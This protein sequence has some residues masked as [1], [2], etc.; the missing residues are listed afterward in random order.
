ME[1]QKTIKKEFTLEGVGLHTG[2]KVV[3][4]FKPA[5]VNTGIVFFRQD[6]SFL[7]KS[8]FYSVLSPDNFPRRTSVGKDGACIHTVEHLMAAFSI[9]GIDN[10]Q[11]DINGE[12]IPGMD[13]SAKE[14]IE[15][16]KASG[17]VEQQAPKNYLVVRDPVWID[18]NKATLVILP[19]PAFR[20][21]Y[22]LDYNSPCV[23]TSF[24]DATLS[25]DVEGCRLG[26]ARTFC[27]EDEVKPLLKMG[28]GKGANYSNT[29]VVSEKGIIDNELRDPDEF[30]KHKILDLIGD[31]YLAGPIKGH[32]IAFRSGHQLNIKLLEKLRRY[33]E[34]A[35]SSGVGTTTSFVPSKD[36][37]GAE[38]IMKILPHRYPFLLVD[39]IL[40]IEKGKKAA[41]IKNVTIND[42]FFQGHFPGKPVMPGVLIIEAMA[43]VGGV[44][45]LA[46]PENR[47]KLAFFMAADNIKFRKTVEPGDQ[48]LIEVTAGKVKSRTGQVHTKAFVNEKIVAEADLMFALVDR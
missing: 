41:G 25:S 5:G 43:Q 39:R 48:L 17:I 6:K 10:I 46:P 22:T 16:I 36:G 38:D 19:Y 14:F 20:I 37:F 29:L 7:I 32:V 9:L 8:D 44:L 24:L 1:K 28:L 13:G 2:E 18:E 15:N 12:E 31:L 27:L 21:S 45:M 42:Y 11:V 35:I 33:K 3:L 23:R 47:G 40:Y 26:F 30:I 4:K 34:K